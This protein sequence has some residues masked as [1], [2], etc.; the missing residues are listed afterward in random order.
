MDRLASP[1]REHI[2]RMM[3]TRMV[4][5]MVMLMSIVVM[6]VVMPMSL[7]VMIVVMLMPIM[8]VVMPMSIMVVVVMVIMPIV[9]MVV[10]VI[11]PIVVMVVVMIVAAAL[12]LFMVMAALRADDLIE[13]FFLQRLTRLHCLKDLFARKLGD[14]SRDKRSLVIELSE[15]RNALLDFLRL[16]LIRA[17]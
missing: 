15:Q 1:A 2:V 11:M 10:M 13:E 9:V 8:V 12:T 14:R 7:V 5:V 6:V 4:M 3:M 17:A 16:R